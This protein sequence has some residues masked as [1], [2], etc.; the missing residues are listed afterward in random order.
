MYRYMSA[1]Q[2]APSGPVRV[3]TG[4]LHRS[5]EAEKSLSPSLARLPSKEANLSRSNELSEEE[6][7]FI[8]E[9]YFGGTVTE[10]S[11]YKFQELK[12]ASLLKGV[13]WGMMS[14]IFSKK[15]Y[16]FKSYTASMYAGYVEQLDYF[17]KKYVKN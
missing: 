15:V 12:C 6:D 1:I 5:A 10:I 17:K 14:E 8:L 11:K 9:E 16:D 2:S 13:L 3:N 7:D 4:R